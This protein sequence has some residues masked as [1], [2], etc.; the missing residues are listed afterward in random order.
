VGA[1]LWPKKEQG[2]VPCSQQGIRCHPVDPAVANL[3]VGQ[4]L[5]QGGSSWPASGCRGVK[6][7]HFGPVKRRLPSP[8]LHH[9]RATL[10]GLCPAVLRAIKELG[11]ALLT[12]PPGATARAAACTGPSP[13]VSETPSVGLVKPVRCMPR[14]KNRRCRGGGGGPQKPPPLWAPQKPSKVSEPRLTTASVI[15]HVARHHPPG[16]NWW[17]RRS[18]GW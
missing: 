10:S 5:L 8:G 2:G 7:E 1:G 14:D 11:P 9:G 18:A 6:L 15:R 3:S 4:E 12:T 13:L 16:S 17:G